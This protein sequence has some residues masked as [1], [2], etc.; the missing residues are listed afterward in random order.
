MISNPDVRGFRHWHILWAARLHCVSNRGSGV[1]MERS[2][3]A[4]HMPVLFSPTIGAVL[5]ARYWFPMGAPRCVPHHERDRPT[6]ARSDC[7][8]AVTNLIPAL[9]CSHV[10]RMRPLPNSCG[11]RGRKLRG[12]S[13]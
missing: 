3:Q 1:G 7:E 10:G 12:K 6:H 11:C 9:S 5:A 4:K 2:S 13:G 8:G